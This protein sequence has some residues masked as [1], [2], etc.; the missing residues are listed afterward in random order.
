VRR[1]LIKKHAFIF[2]FQFTGD[3]DLRVKLT[4]IILCPILEKSQVVY[5]VP[6]IQ[7]LV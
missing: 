7:N 1:K 5:F 2:A 6:F 4:R 3:E